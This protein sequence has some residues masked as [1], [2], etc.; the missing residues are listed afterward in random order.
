MARTLISPPPAWQDAN[1]T[2]ITLTDWAGSALCLCLAQSARGVIA[3]GCGMGDGDVDVDVDMGC[4]EIRQGQQRKQ[5]IILRFEAVLA[6][7]CFF[8]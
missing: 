1:G 4:G 5:A 6:S 8:L 7:S 3:G 2:P